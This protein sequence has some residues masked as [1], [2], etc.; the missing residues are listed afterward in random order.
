[1]VK[2]QRGREIHLLLQTFYFFYLFTN[3]CKIIF[4]NRDCVKLI[5]LLCLVYTGFMTPNY[6]TSRPEDRLVSGTIIQCRK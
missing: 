2:E 3:Y 4:L 1:M 6:L 5:I